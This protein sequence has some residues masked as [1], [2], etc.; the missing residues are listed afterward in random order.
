M[1]C[2]EGPGVYKGHF[3]HLSPTVSLSA[4]CE[5]VLLGICIVKCLSSG[6][7]FLKDF[8]DDRGSGSSERRKVAAAQLQ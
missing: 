1:L 8:S 4:H 7:Q 3:Q 2:V 5:C 6:Y